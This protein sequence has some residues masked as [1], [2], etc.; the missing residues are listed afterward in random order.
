MAR[1][2]YILFVY[3]LPAL[4]C[5][6]LL[7]A[8]FGIRVP[9]FL[10]VIA[11]P[12]VGLGLT[13]VVGT[14]ALAR[15]NARLR[16]HSVPESESRGWPA[17][18]RFVISRLRA[19]LDPAVLAFASPAENFA[20]RNDLD[21]L[22]RGRS[23]GAA[24]S[25][26][27]YA[28][29]IQEALLRD[30]LR[31]VLRLAAP[32]R[33]AQNIDLANAYCGLPNQ[34]KGLMHRLDE[35]G[36]DARHATRVITEQDMDLAVAA[37]P[38]VLQ[39]F[40]CD[41]PTGPR[42]ANLLASNRPPESLLPGELNRLL[43]RVADPDAELLASLHL[44]D[45]A[46]PLLS[47]PV[48]PAVL[49]EALLDRNRMDE[50]W[51]VLTP[52]RARFDQDVRLRQLLGLY[53]SRRGD[54]EE[55]VA[56]LH[57]A[58]KVLEA[59]ERSGSPADEETY[60]I[61]AG[62]YK[63]LADRKAEGADWL[64]RCHDT[65]LEG[66]ERSGRRNGYLGINTASTALWLGDKELARRTAAEV[67][68]Q[69]EEI[70]DGLAKMPEGP[71]Q[72]TYWDQVTLAEAYLLEGRLEE[73]GTLYRDAFLRHADRS[74]IVMVSVKQASRHLRELGLADRTADVLGGH[75]SSDL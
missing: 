1:T 62:V 68:K 71:R 50:A 28:T 12:L 9:W 42:R 17:N 36:W 58:R 7:L 45:G 40:F 46:G 56:A 41:S 53:W 57:D 70:R 21:R 49:A 5:L 51:R 43:D 69:F 13:L 19:A 72:L 52:A 31:P 16:D 29:R 33:V 32:G 10:A 39:W 22:D 54:A 38:R 75:A 14:I 24:E 37:V 35:M 63:R 26:V 23:A 66:W 20:L 55:N 47:S 64:R 2:H 59:I 27:L 11:F 67:R 65:Y 44:D 61:L 60:G 6:G 15:E 3:L 18:L 73:A 30:A 34:L 8:T 25:V 74:G 4:I 48:L